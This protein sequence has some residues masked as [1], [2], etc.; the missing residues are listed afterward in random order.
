[1]ELSTAGGFHELDLGILS[2]FQG[3]GSV[4]VFDRPRRRRKREKRRHAA[5]GKP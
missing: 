4:S 3:P 1:M 2:S 5:I